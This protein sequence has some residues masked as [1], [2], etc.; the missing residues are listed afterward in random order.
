MTQEALSGIGLFLALESS[1]VFH[2][3]SERRYRHR[4]KG[5]HHELPQDRPG[6]EGP[7]QARP[8]CEEARSEEA[9]SEASTH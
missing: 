2:V 1:N 6:E 9:G 5:D 3:E 7:L 4:D 8:G